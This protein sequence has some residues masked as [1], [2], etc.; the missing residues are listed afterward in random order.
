M[1]QSE[2]TCLTFFLLEE[3]EGGVISFILPGIITP[4]PVD[5]ENFMSSVQLLEDD[6]VT[7]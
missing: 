5:F 3:E 7:K 4:Q 6:L 1:S 2:L